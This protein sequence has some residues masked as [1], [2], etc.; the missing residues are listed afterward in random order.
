MFSVIL[1]SVPSVKGGVSRVTRM[2]GPPQAYTTLRSTTAAATWMAIPV[3][4]ISSMMLPL[5][6][7]SISS[8]LESKMTTPF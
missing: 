3:L 5:T 2:P 4:R 6:T 8:A 7:T 1:P